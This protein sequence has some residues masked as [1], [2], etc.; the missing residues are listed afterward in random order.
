MREY[1]VVSKDVKGEAAAGEALSA[2]QESLDNAR[3]LV[4]RTRSLL[5]GETA[6]DEGEMAMI[7][8]HA[9]ANPPP[10]SDPEAPAE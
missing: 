4:E 5:A 7:A 1:R 10:A 2:M 8:A 9:A 3:Q 6:Y